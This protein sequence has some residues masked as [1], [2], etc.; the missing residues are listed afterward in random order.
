MEESLCREMGRV[1]KSQNPIAVRSRSMLQQ[2][3]LELLTEQPY[4]Q[5]TVTALCEHAQLGRK[6]FYRNYAE[7]DDILRE[8]IACLADGFLEKLREQAPFG[9]TAF[10]QTLFAYWKPYADLFR[11]LEQSGEFRFVQREFERV[12]ARVGGWFTCPEAMREDRTFQ[13]YCASFVSG[14]CYAL[15]RDWMCGGAVEPVE[16]MTTLFCQIRRLKA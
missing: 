16:Q 6:T 3:M 1:E 9:D 5:I 13:R 2:A 10:A 11:L 15:L 14:G 12:A 4:G 7:K 8:Y